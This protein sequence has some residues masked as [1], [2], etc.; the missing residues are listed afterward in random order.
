MEN[1]SHA[2]AAGL[3]A[4]LLGCGM[5]FS[6]WWFS[7]D[8]QAT[9][10]VVLVAR[11][12]IGGLAP[13][14]RVRFRGLAAG[15]VDEVGFD[16]LDSRNILVRILVDE[17]LPLTRGTRASLGTMGVT[18]LV[19]VQL[20]DRGDDPTPLV[21]ADGQPPRIALEPGL[22]AQITDR[23]LALVQ[24]FQGVGE[25]IATMFDADSAERFRQLLARLESAADGVDR[26]FAE[27]PKTLEAIRT[28]FSAE[29]VQRLSA[30]LANLEESSAEVAPT[31]VELRGLLG[32]MDGMAARLD[33]AALATSNSLID[34]TLPRLNDLLRDLTTTSRRIGRLVEE[35]ESTPQMLLTGRGAR[36]PGPGEAGFDP[37]QP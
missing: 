5:L 21:G 26:S 30:A 10:E 27:A 12:D 1:R 14:A 7:Q 37:E 15:V 33:E 29:N 20:D 22:L 4:L 11:D 31:I 8:K 24:Q 25:R 13:Q 18:G 36:A 32:R 9:R 23:A 19:F 35:V 28:V 6:I 16:P 3:F 34:G 17:T 2:I